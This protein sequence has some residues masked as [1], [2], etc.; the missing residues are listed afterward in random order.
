M[1]QH[2]RREVSVCEQLGDMRQV[3]PNLVPA[4]R[5][6]WVVCLDLNHTAVRPQEEV[7]CRLEMVKTHHLIAFFIDI[8]VVLIMA[9]TCYGGLLHH[10]HMESG[11][12]V[13]D[14][15]AHFNGVLLKCRNRFGIG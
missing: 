13:L 3:L 7:M 4:D 6:L 14:E 5:I 12:A 15:I 11:H 10:S 2:W 9:L 1:N 8:C